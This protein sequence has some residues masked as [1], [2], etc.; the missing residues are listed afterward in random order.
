[1]GEYLDRLIYTSAKNALP[2]SLWKI[3]EQC[4]E[5]GVPTMLLSGLN[6]LCLAVKIKKPARILELGTAMGVSGTA[7][8]L[9]CEGLLTTVE[10]NEESVKVAEGTFLKFGVLKRVTQL[11]GDTLETVK[12]IADEKFDFIFLDCNKAAYPLVYEYLKNM[13]N[14]GGVLFADNVLFRGYVEN[15]VET[16]KIYRTLVEKIDR[17]NQMVASDGDMITTLLNVGDGLLIAVKK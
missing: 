13:L 15:R 14:A 8:L 5:K 2:E 10:K 4:R 7:M 6:E 17:F 12:K 11:T 3:S 9:S 16:P 1:M